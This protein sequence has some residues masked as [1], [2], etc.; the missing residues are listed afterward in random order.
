MIIQ[1]PQLIQLKNPALKELE[2]L[3]VHQKLLFATKRQFVG[4]LST[5]IFFSGFCMIMRSDGP[6]LFFG[7]FSLYIA[8]RSCGRHCID[9]T[10]FVLL[11]Y[12]CLVRWV[13]YEYSVV[14]WVIFFCFVWRGQLESCLRTWFY[15]QIIFCVPH[16]NY[17][18]VNDTLVLIM[19]S[20]VSYVLYSVQYNH[21]NY[22]QNLWYK[23]IETGHV[24]F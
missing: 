6:P 15:Q 5:S 20:S 16:L 14:L 23:L 4:Q 10:N 17:Y 13:S 12:L 3:A 19:F 8:R 1:F 18:S 7:S 24:F 9:C 11:R 2:R 21:L 22:I